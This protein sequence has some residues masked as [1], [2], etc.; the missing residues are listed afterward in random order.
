MKTNRDQ[1]NHALHHLRGDTLSE[2][3]SAMET[4]S[5]SH[6]IHHRRWMAATAACLSVVFLLGAVV[7]IPMMRAD[8]APLDTKCTK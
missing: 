4:P 6:A 1:L 7:G 3:V 2:V 8:E 5:V